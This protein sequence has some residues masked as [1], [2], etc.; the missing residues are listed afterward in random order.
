MNIISK[1][2][3]LLSFPDN[4]LII[5]S[6]IIKNKK[7]KVTGYMISDLSDIIQ[8]KKIQN[9]YILYKKNSKKLILHGIPNNSEQQIRNVWNANYKKQ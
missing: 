8:K 1:L 2:K 3:I 7:G 6:G 4:I 5:Q 9:G